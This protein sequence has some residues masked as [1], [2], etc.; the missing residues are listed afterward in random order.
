[1]IPRLSARLP[2]IGLRLDADDGQ[3]EGA[4]D[5]N[6]GNA[7][8]SGEEPPAGYHDDPFAD[9]AAEPVHGVPDP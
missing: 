2:P 1:M 3:D 4:D 7:T 8:F 5:R 9:S 6:L